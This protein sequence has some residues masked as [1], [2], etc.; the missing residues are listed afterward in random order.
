MKIILSP[1]RQDS[2]LKVVK[3]KD[4]LTINGKKYD[5]SVVP[6]GALLP[7]DAVDCPWLAADVERIEG[8]LHL[9]LILPI[10]ADAS[11]AA[12]FPA[13]IIDPADGPLEFPK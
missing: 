11:E 12:R 9:T 5:F 6:N 2:T 7:K 4:A 13:P 8:I 3:N 10:S 1:Q